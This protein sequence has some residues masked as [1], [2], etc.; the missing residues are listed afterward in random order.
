MSP[1]FSDSRSP[2]VIDHVALVSKVN[3]N[4]TIETISGNWGATSS[5][6]ILH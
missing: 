6:S 3:S 4:G 5:T 2:A 1:V